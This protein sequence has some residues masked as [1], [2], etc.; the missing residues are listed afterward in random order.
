V[1][2]VWLASRPFCPVSSLAYLSSDS[3]C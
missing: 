2:K 1:G 3:F